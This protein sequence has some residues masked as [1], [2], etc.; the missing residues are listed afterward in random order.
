MLSQFVEE[1][2]VPRGI[3]NS[4]LD[5]KLARVDERM[6]TRNYLAA[7]VQPSRYEEREY[8]Q[9]TLGLSKSLASILMRRNGACDIEYSFNFD[10]HIIGHILELS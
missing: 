7:L 5:S 4:L 8:N 9:N 2:P 1:K 6:H 3:R 10:L